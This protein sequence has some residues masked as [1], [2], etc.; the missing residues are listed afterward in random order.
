MPYK[1]FAICHNIVALLECLMGNFTDHKDELNMWYQTIKV[2]LDESEA[3]DTASCHDD[4]C[5]CK[6]SPYI[7]ERPP[8][9]TMGV[10]SLS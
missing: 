9:W 2:R 10:L 6:S 1:I 4:S 3:K 8:Y 7:L 5:T